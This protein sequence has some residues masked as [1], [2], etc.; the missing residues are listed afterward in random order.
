MRPVVSITGTFI[1]SLSMGLAGQSC[2]APLLDQ[3]HVVGAPGNDIAILSA[4]SL[5]QTFTAGLSGTLAEVDLQI[6]KNTGT[7]GDLTFTIRTTSGG[8]PNSNDSQSLFQTIITLDSIP[9][10]DSVFVPVPLTAIDVSSAHITVTSGQ[11]L[12]L[13]LARNGA[14]NPPW[15]AWR[16]VPGNYSGGFQ[17]TRSG[18]SSPWSQTVQEGGFQTFVSVVPEPPSLLLAVIAAGGCG[19]ACCLRRKRAPGAC[20]HHQLR[21]YRQAIR[22]WEEGKG[23]RNRFSTFL[24]FRF[25]APGMWQF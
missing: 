4:Q 3:T 14:G 6:S 1:A 12:A 5:A 17:F 10:V 23:V 8:I 2:A 19:T 11:V 16:S 24:H 15:A 9:T 13:A 25:L 22:E 21:R 18:S 7:T 20:S